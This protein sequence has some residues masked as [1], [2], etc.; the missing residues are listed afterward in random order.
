MGIEDTAIVRRA[1]LGA[2]AII[3]LLGASAC[4]EPDLLF[5]VSTPGT[6]VAYVGL[7]EPIIVTVTNG[8]GAGATLGDVS[9]QAIGL[10][11]P[12]ALDTTRTTCA[13]GMLLLKSGGSC[14]LY[15][16]LAATEAGEYRTPLDFDY[17]WGS[18]EARSESHELVVNAVLP[19]AGSRVRSTTAPSHCTWPP[20]RNT[21]FGIRPR[22]RCSSGT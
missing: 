1:Q 14:K 7:S 10:V 20:A 18:G 13:S 6:G 16:L 17:S 12:F 2:I 3:A 4:D 8:G 22:V 21:G 9:A 19:L 15:L 11:S 5:T